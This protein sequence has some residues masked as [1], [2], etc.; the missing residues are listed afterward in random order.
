M[1]TLYVFC[2]GKS[3]Q[4]FCNQ[5]LAPY[6]YN[7][8]FMHVHSILVAISFRRGRA[9][10][11]GIQNYQT[12]KKDIRNKLK[13]RKQKDVYF[14]TM[15]DLYA[16]PKNFPA[17]EKSTR[18]AENPTPYVVGLEQAFGEDIGDHRFVPYIQ[19]HE[20]ETLLFVDP[21]AF[22]VSFENCKNL[23]DGMRKIKKEFASI[24]HINDGVSTAPSKRIIELLPEYKGRKASVGPDV[25]ELIGLEK[26]R[27]ASPHFD[28]WIQTLEGLGS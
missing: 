9:H 26:L 6:L 21:E 16:L 22:K 3:E 11:G 28:R 25:A 17:K 23:I 13:S 18:N 10:R 20:F 4:G 14:T 1:K 5:V 19:L 27:R 24:E 12:V 2:E 8:G 15:I 7:I